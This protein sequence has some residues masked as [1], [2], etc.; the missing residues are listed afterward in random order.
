M[1]C[2]ICNTN[3]A[4]IIFTVIVNNEKKD[5]KICKK[6][7]EEKGFNSPLG[8]IPFLL[9]EIIFGMAVDQINEMVDKRI[10]DINIECGSCGMTHK[11]FKTSGLLGCESC[12]ES[13]KDD[14]KIILR[15]IHGNNKHYSFRKGKMS[16]TGTKISLL[17]K[18]LEE[19]V[20]N[21]EFEKAAILRD[22]IKDMKR[23]GK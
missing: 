13:F 4:N 1:N 2:Q 17:K 20:K 12:Y 18:E 16:S 5:I 15:R 23:N 3:S 22:E 8:G 6:C 11:E 19:A 14:L 7:A 21:E 10:D 9:G